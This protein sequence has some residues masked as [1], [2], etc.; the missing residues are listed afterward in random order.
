MK[1]KS[2]PSEW[3]KKLV[4]G[5]KIAL[6]V[7]TALILLPVVSFRE[8]ESHSDVTLYK[9]AFSAKKAHADAMHFTMLA[10]CCGGSC[11]ISACGGSGCGTG[12]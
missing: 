11:G 9:R 8:Q 12:C 1:Q 4:A 5:F 2:I 6:L 10:P 7:I 3:I